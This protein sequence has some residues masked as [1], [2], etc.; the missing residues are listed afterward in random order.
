MVK[1]NV[2]VGVSFEPLIGGVRAPIY[3]SAQSNTTV[4]QSGNPLFGVHTGTQARPAAG[5]WEKR[6]QQ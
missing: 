3:L 4:N 5:R 1:H 6:L 2:F